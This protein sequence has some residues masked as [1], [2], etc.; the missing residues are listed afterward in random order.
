MR[1]VNQTLLWGFFA[2]TEATL[3]PLSRT[4]HYQRMLALR[5]HEHSSSGLHRLLDAGRVER[6]RP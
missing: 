1:S 2:I 4:A 5:L 6:E 3:L